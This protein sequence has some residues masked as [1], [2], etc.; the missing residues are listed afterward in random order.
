[1]L[2]RLTAQYWKCGIDVSSD[3]PSNWIL[4]DRVHKKP[5]RSGVRSVGCRQGPA[6]ELPVDR[7]W[8]GLALPYCG[9]Q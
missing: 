9:G 6:S 8:L 1:M 3:G 2:S 5:R 4:S 7:G